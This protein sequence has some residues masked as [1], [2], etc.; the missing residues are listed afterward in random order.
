[1][2]PDGVLYVRQRQ[3]AVTY[4]K[5]RL[6]DGQVTGFS[7][8]ELGIWGLRFFGLWFRLKYYFQDKMTKNNILLLGQANKIT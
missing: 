5:D 2:E 8:P 6:Q 7:V 3:W 4:P 1:M